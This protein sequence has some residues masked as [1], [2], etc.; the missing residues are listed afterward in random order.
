[1]ED[2]LEAYLML[3]GWPWLKQAKT[4][5]DCGNNTLTI[6]VD[7]KTL[8]LEQKSEEWYILPKDLAILMILMIRKEDWRM[9]MRNVYTMPYQSCGM[10]KK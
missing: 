10:L 4:Y 2:T 7:T 1:M 6:I 3:L 9:E 5:H 8:T